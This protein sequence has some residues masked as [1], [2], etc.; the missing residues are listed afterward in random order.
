MEQN[1]DSGKT[2]TLVTQ[3]NAAI[4]KT[5]LYSPD[6]P[7]VNRSVAGAYDGLTDL[8]EHLPSVTLILVGDQLVVNDKPIKSGGSPVEKFVQILRQRGAERITF[9]KGISKSDLAKW[10]ENLAAPDM[11]P[12][13]SGPFIRLGKVKVESAQE[14]RESPTIVD[15][16]ELERFQELCSLRNIKLDELKAIYH[17]IKQRKPVDIQGVDDMIREFIVAF[18]EGINPIRLLAHLK[19]TDEY[20]FTHVV[21]VCILTL[22]QAQKLGF[23]GKHLYDIGVASVLHDAGKLFIPDEIINKPGALDPEERAIIE[24]HT[25]RGAR[26]ILTLEGIPKLAVLGAL[27]HHIKYDG[28][29]YPRVK[30]KWRPNIVSQMIAI[31]DVFDA[32]RSRR[33]YKDPKPQDLVFKILQE[34]KGTSFNPKL[35]DNFIDMSGEPISSWSDSTDDEAIHLPPMASGTQ[36]ATA[37]Q[38]SVR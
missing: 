15:G 13:H 38:R 16:P 37:D 22:G 27:E 9:V 33:S 20:T 35:V 18:R 28:T 1:A 10:V 26:Y 36:E 2:L 21:N 11:P 30:E 8:L 7:E 29:G 14:D 3:L 23:R 31:A 4:T 6:H 32:M 19:S 5:H 25:L 24:T 12:L 34:E 17:G